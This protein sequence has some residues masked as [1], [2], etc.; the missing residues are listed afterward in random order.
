LLR[1][2]KSPPY[3]TLLVDTSLMICHASG[4]FFLNFAAV[5]LECG[6]LLT[7]VRT[8][9]HKGIGKFVLNIIIIIIATPADKYGG[10]DT[11]FYR[12]FS[13]FGVP[14]TK[15]SLSDWYISRIW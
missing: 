1:E 10:P 2:Q 5:R 13:S 3:I 6:T 11:D 15:T 9:V 8:H 7:Q 14:Q 4:S 12:L